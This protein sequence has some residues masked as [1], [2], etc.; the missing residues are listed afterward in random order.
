V[1]PASGVER[2]APGTS[3]AIADAP[4]KTHGGVPRRRP[5]ARW[6]LWAALRPGWAAVV[7]LAA[8]IKLVH[9]K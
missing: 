2:Q 5:A 7:S 8:R 6:S 9:L 4:D 1:P 3:P